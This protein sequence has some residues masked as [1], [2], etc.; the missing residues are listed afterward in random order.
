MMGVM[1]RA[2]LLL[3]EEAER[4]LVNRLTFILSFIMLTTG[5]VFYYSF[6]G[7]PFELKSLKLEHKIEEE[8]KQKTF[9]EKLLTIINGEEKEKKEEKKWSDHVSDWWNALSEDETITETMSTDTDINELEK[10]EAAPFNNSIKVLFKSLLMK[11]TDQDPV[12]VVKIMANQTSDSMSETAQPWSLFS[13]NFAS[14]ESMQIGNKDD[15]LETLDFTQNEEQKQTI[16]DNSVDV[17]K[18]DSQC[19]A[20][21]P[22]VTKNIQPKT[23]VAAE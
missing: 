17:L 18:N 11:N 21:C 2:D 12:G 9:Y 8:V 6:Y 20:V 7:C 5:Y 15:I 22:C 16:D 14:A 23:I 1:R 10:S 3:G 4:P 13:F 19:V